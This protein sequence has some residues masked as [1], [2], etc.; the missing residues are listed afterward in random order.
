MLNSYVLQVQNLV[1]DSNETL[2]TY[3]N[4]VLWINEGRR[5]LAMESQSCRA[6]ATATASGNII[7][8]ASVTPPTGMSALLDV[9]KVWP[10]SSSAPPISMRSWEWYVQFYANNLLG[11][12]PTEWCQ[13]ADG[14]NGAIYLNGTGGGTLNL[15]GVW[16]PVDLVSDATPEAIPVPWQDAVKYFAAYL[17]YANSQRSADAQAMLELFS[18][19][20]A[21]ARKMSRP[22]V[23]PYL[24]ARDHS[25]GSMTEG[26][27]ALPRGQAP[28]R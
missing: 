2:Y 18:G 23:L 9:R 17:A 15:D 1:H 22:T 7:T 26:D 27:L 24:L 21:R 16:L 20:T 12:A 19:F 3:P 11:T 28:G 5:Q 25:Q 10:T 13:Y 8:F 6:M 14:V 4:I